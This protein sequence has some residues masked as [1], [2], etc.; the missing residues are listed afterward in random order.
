MSGVFIK[1]HYWNRKILKVN[2]FTIERSEEERTYVPTDVAQTSL[3]VK[4]AFLALSNQP[5][6]FHLP[7][8]SMVI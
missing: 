8:D 6:M 5:A 1:Y 2:Y 7:T 3:F 4:H